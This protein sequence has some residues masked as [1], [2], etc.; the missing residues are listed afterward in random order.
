M[1]PAAIAAILHDLEGKVTTSAWA[2]R[3]RSHCAAGQVLRWLDAVGVTAKKGGYRKLIV[4]LTDALIMINAAAL[5]PPNISGVY[6]PRARQPYKTGA[7]KFFR[8]VSVPGFDPLFHIGAEFD[9]IQ[10]WGMGGISPPK[11]GEWPTGIVMDYIER[12]NGAVVLC[13]R[14]RFNGYELERIE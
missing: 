12:S 14:Y 13:G 7:L 6:Q 9:A 11:P 8:V 1:T 4:P 3:L 5:A 2:D 10:V